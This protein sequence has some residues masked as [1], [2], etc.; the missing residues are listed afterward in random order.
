LTSSNVFGRY[1]S[2]HGWLLAAT[3][4]SGFDLDEDAAAAARAEFEKKLAILKKKW[5]L[6]RSQKP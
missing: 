1:F 5:A 2:T 4:G 6:S 3:T